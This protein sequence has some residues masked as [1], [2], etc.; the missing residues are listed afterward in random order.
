MKKTNNQGSKIGTNK[1]G[2]NRFSK[3]VSWLMGI[4]LSVFSIQTYAQA[5]AAL[6]FDGVDD[7][8]DLGTTLGN[9]GT[10]NF[11]FE[12]WFK[13]TATGDRA[14]VSKRAFCGATNFWNLRFINGALHF[15]FYG[16]AGVDVVSP[17]A[18]YNDGN[19]HHVACVRNINVYSLYVDG[20]QVAQGTSGPGS[21]S[22]YNFTNAA[23]LYFGSGPCGN[24]L[25]SLDET[26][27]WNVARTTYEIQ[28]SYSCEI[29]GASTGLL[30]NMHYNQGIGGGTNTGITTANDDSGNNNNGTLTN[31]ALTGATSNW[32]TPGAVTS[33]VSCAAIASQNFQL[34]GS[35]GQ[36]WN[37]GNCYKLTTTHQS[38]FG[39]MWY[40]QKVDLTQDFDLSANLNFGTGNSPGADGITFAFQNVCTSA[41]TAGQDIGVGGVNPSLVVEFDTYQNAVYGD[42]AA[43]HIAIQKNGDLNHGGANALVAPVQIDPTNVNVETGLDYL[44]HILWTAST[45]TLTVSVNGNLRATYTGDI[46][47]QIFASSPYVYWGFTAG[48][49]GE[50]NNQSVCVTTMPTNIVSLVAN[51]TICNGSGYQANVPGYTTY[52]W[53]PTTGVSN[54]A[55]GN[56]VLSPS[57]STTYTLSVTDACANVQTQTIAITVNPLPSVTA[58]GTATIC[59]GTG[60]S[61][62]A[63]GGTTYSWSPAGDLDNANIAN[64]IATP[65]TTTTYTVTGT[66]NGCSATDIV[67]ITVN[68][69]AATTAS[70]ATTICNGSTAQLNA[71]GPATF[72]WAP[73]GSLDD[74]NIANP[75]ASPTTTTTYTVTGTG[76]GCSSTATVVI[77]VNPIPLM[78]LNSPTICA[79]NMASIICLSSPAGGTYTWTPALTAT[80][81]I[82]YYPTATTSYTVTH[83]VG[84]CSNTASGM[85]TVNPVP[86]ASAGTAATI[87]PGA[88][89]PLIS[90]GGT[91]YSWSPA[92][93]LSNAN[94]DNPDASPTVTTTYTVT[95]GNSFSCIATD[96]VTITVNA[97]NASAG[98]NT[99]I[100]CGNATTLG[101]SGGITYSWTPATGLSATN[102]ANPLANPTS[103]TT[104]TVTVGNGSCTADANVTVTVNPVPA[105]A[106]T[107]VSITC[108]N[109]TTLN[110]TGG[111]T[112]S[113]AP[114][115][116]LSATNIANPVAN[117]QATT[118]YTVTVG[119]GSCSGT[120]TVT[121]TVVGYTTTAGS[122]VTICQGLNTALN[123]TVTPSNGIY[124]NVNTGYTFSS[125]LG[126][127]SNF[128]GGTII[129]DSN[130]PTMDDAVSGPITIP[131]FTFNNQTFT[132]IYIST[133]GFISFGSAPSATEYYPLS[134]SA[135]YAGCVAPFGTDIGPYSTFNSDIRT[136]Q[137]GSDFI[138]QWKNFGRFGSFGIVDEQIS[139]AIYLNTSNNKISVIYSSLAF[140]SS[141]NYYPQVGIRGANN[142]FPT[143]INN[144]TIPLQGG[145]WLN[146]TTA[147][148]SNGNTCGI[149][150]SPSATNPGS[151]T[152]FVWTPATFLP[153]TY[154]WSPSAGLSSSTVLN[155]VASPSGTTTYTLTA[156]YGSCSSTSSV[157]VT[158]DLCNGITENTDEVNVN[159]FPNP[160]GNV[161]NVGF[162]MNTNQTVQLNLVDITGK[163]VFAKTVSLKSGSN[164][165][166]ISLDEYATGL[167]FLKVQTGTSSSTKKIV[168]E[169]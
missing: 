138:I 103:T 65:L 63:N 27:L 88:T 38:D 109:S 62:S 29:N 136:N 26:R 123:G 48:T 96:T 61:L 116:G 162:E 117:P 15:E 24:F 13:S 53:T 154:S 119:N 93:G 91:T 89:V 6:N 160:A 167:Y 84:G 3:K 157:V 37:G 59:A 70:G 22:P 137:I 149:N 66:N 100:V 95:V 97:V 76:G 152:V 73:A 101:A 36:D 33:G 20:V 169:H 9:W 50:F 159:V 44:V 34:N 56:P 31:F 57:S 81:S 112:Y 163:S 102:I 64:P 148:T 131:S 77:T 142:T 86:T 134:S 145:I 90:S 45:Q 130:S 54:P 132:S 75:V 158:V 156:N 46:V 121:V 83:T 47:T 32:V 104:Y 4:V 139:F 78:I 164:K 125:N 42:P 161:L 19:W 55:I 122:D 28:Q 79:G 16:A 43:D 155:P 23:S 74:A 7:R 151:G 60:T 1:R 110:A 5:G 105:S 98:S 68:A 126:S 52:S 39:S 168:I 85:V 108:G 94:I 40:K 124:Q 141:A 127:Y 114:S 87:C 35:G 41:G 30:V 82:N 153:V 120:G 150:G 107:D 99:S 25:G 129:F 106:G 18:T 67:T 165:E 8:V 11:T 72:S 118:T 113:W 133:N 146:N 58:G 10:G 21:A 111:T 80:N 51:A 92:T 128:T 115:T 135:S 49:G 71:S 143:N 69:I 166:V 147:G 144:R 2:A 17:L 14:I 140:T 12:T